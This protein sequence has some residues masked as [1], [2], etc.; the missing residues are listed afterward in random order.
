M[1][2]TQYQL[3]SMGE[4]A[5]NWPRGPYEPDVLRER[6]FSLCRRLQNSQGRAVPVPPLEDFGIH[7]LFIT[8]CLLSLLCDHYWL[9]LEFCTL[10]VTRFL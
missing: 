2:E 1:R 8:L 9:D 10:V 4:M 7:V 5:S 3:A 6:H